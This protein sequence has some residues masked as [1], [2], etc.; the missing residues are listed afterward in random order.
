MKKYSMCYLATQE[1][2][3]VPLMEHCQYHISALSPLM[4]STINN[5]QSFLEWQKCHPSIYLAI[6][7]SK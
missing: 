3:K 5:L 4:Q 2:A 6:G 7:L 1:V